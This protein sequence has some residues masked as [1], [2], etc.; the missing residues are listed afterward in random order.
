[1]S[2]AKQ[3]PLGQLQL[4]NLYD[5]STAQVVIAPLYDGLLYRTSGTDETPSYKELRDCSKHP[6]VKLALDLL[7]GELEGVPWRYEFNQNIPAHVAEKFKGADKWI[8]TNVRRIRNAILTQGIRN[9]LIYGYSPFEVIYGYNTNNGLYEV[10]Q[11]K[12]LL[13]E[14]TWILADRDGNFCGFEQRRRELERRARRNFIVGGAATAGTII[15]ARHLAKK[16]KIAKIADEA[17]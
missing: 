11:L 7:A 12:P 10:K 3:K 8:E 13:H 4:P 5:K 1:M 17:K 2:P 16:D 15:T 6:L 14:Y 9:M